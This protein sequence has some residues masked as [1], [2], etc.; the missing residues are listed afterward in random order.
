VERCPSPL[1]YYSTRNHIVD[2]LVSRSKTFAAEAVDHDPRRVP[3]VR[4]GRTEPTVISAPKVV[5]AASTQAVA[6]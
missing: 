5:D 1:D 3:L 2:F 4:I 6:R